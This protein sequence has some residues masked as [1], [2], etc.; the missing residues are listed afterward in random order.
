MLCVKPRQHPSTHMHLRDRGENRKIKCKKLSWVKIKI[1]ERMKKR[2]G[3]R[4]KPTKANWCK[5]SDSLSPTNRGH[6]AMANM[7]ENGPHLLG[8]L[9]WFFLLSMTSYGIAYPFGQFASA[10][11][12]CPLPT[13][14]TAPTYSRQGTGGGGDG[15]GKGSWHTMCRSRELNNVTQPIIVFGSSAMYLAWWA[16]FLMASCWPAVEFSFCFVFFYVL[17]KQSYG[18][19]GCL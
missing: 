5:G 7:E 2:G 4:G 15:M 17:Y 3:G 16:R 19:V 14:G 11:L 9:L 13:S 8:P 10:I 12:L 18:V 6:W 1:V